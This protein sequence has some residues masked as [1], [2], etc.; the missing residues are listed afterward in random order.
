ML[1]EHC[2]EVQVMWG[3]GLFSGYWKAHEVLGEFSIIVLIA[4]LI[5][6][7]VQKVAVKHLKLI[8]QPPEEDEEGVGGRKRMRMRMNHGIN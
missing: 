7:P 2:R 4:V 1:G 6:T 5:H 3:I 8:C